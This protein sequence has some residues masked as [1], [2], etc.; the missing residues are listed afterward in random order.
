MKDQ[1]NQTENE[2]L[3]L[4]NLAKIGDDES[5]KAIIDMHSGVCVSI[6]KKYTNI[7]SI[8]G[9]TKTDIESSKDFIIYN[10]IK[11]YD[12]SK[13]SKFSTW[14]ANQTRFYCLNSLNK[15]KNNQSLDE[16]SLKFFFDK[17]SNDSFKEENENEYINETINDIKNILNSI[18]NKKIKTCIEKKY[19]SGYNKTY[20][21]IAKEMNVTVQT[22]INWHNK[23][24]KL[25]KQRLKYKNLD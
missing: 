8:A 24:I 2:E 22:I 10:S 5:I 23:F 1:K 7:P 4:L 20:T 15:I 21:E 12:Q 25:A 18:S 6:Y 17:K 9:Y 13:G 11:T 3:S 19:L 16:D 14:L